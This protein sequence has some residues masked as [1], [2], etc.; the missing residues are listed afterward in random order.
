M[1]LNKRSAQTQQTGRTRDKRAHNSADNQLNQKDPLEVSTG[2]L[3][4]S[5][6]GSLPIEADVQWQNRRVQID[7]CSHGCYGVFSI[8][9]RQRWM[10]PVV[11]WTRTRY[12][13]ARVD[14]GRMLGLVGELQTMS[15]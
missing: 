5:D 8:Q 9:Y 13:A 11:W 12:G 14:A 6:S 3:A 7:A 4:I 15:S 10:L 2:Q 1:V